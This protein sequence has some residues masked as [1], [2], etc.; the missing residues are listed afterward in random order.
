MSEIHHDVGVRKVALSPHG[1]SQQER[2]LVYI[3]LKN[4]LFICPTSQLPGLRKRVMAQKLGTHVDTVAWNE[5]SNALTAIADSQLVTFFYPNA[6]YVD[7]DLLRLASETRDGS[8]FGKS[9]RI[10]S[11]YGATV[12]VRREDG[13]IIVLGVAPFPMAVYGQ[14]R[15]NKWQETVRL[16]QSVGGTCL[17]ATLAGMALEHGELEA[18][19]TGL[20][21]LGLVDKAQ[22]IR[23]IHA[24]PAG[25]VRNKV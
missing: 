3:D 15:S 4:E 2:R 11:F 12:T 20:C 21:A 1:A 9:P 8:E 23:R 7:K 10:V 24:M 16:C 17:W 19:E 6:P 5:N 25:E 22:H 18:A 14:I 13:A